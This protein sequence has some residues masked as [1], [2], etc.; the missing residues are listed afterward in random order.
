LHLSKKLLF[1][2]KIIVLGAACIAIA[3]IYAQTKQEGKNKGTAISSSTNFPAP[4]PPPLPP[5][6]PPPAPPIPSEIPPVPPLPPVPPVPAVGEGSEY[7]YAEIING[8][9]MEVSIHKIKGVETITVKK[10]GNVQHIKMST[11]QANRKYYEKK[12][13]QLPPPPPP[14]LKIKEIDEI[15][16]AAPNEN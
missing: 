8:N 7:N 12:Y 15:P 14:E 5:P 1:M 2:K 3:G 4:P 11:W 13:G 9:G 10:D 6:P 16:A